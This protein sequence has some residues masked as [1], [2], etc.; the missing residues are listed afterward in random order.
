M[1]R[2][3]QESSKEFLETFE[4]EAR[5]LSFPP[6]VAV[7]FAKEHLVY[8]P[9][10]ALDPASSLGF[11]WRGEHKAHLEINGNLLDVLRREIRTVVCV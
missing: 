5:L 6:D 10:E 1:V 11:A 7:K 4:R 9:E 8:R 2:L 3:K